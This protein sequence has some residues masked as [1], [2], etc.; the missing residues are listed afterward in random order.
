MKE[1]IRLV[2]DHRFDPEELYKRQARSS[3]VTVE[4][5]NVGWD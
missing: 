5:N 2:K 3:D 1:V 4:G